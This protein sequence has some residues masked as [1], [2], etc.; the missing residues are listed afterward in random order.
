MIR[1]A[2][3]FTAAV[4]LLGMLAACGAAGSSDATP[5]DLPSPSSSPQ[6]GLVQLVSPLTGAFD[7]PITFAD[8]VSIRVAHLTHKPVG[9]GSGSTNSD[10]PAGAAA[11]RVTLVITAGQAPITGVTGTAFLS[12]GAEGTAAENFTDDSQVSD[13]STVPSTIPGGTS[14]TQHW[15]WAVPAAGQSHAVLVFTIDPLH[16]AD[17]VGPVTMTR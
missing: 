14:L 4:A 1:R 10:V 9:E 16:E 8:G 2:Y 13:G 3:A 17:F 15:A 6:A 5:P 11:A 7:K 12:Y